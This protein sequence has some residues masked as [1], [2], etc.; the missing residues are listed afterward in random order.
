[1]IAAVLLSLATQSA[2]ASMTPVRAAYDACVQTEAASIGT[3]AEITEEQADLIVARCHH[4]IGPVID[5]IVVQA[6]PLTNLPPGTETS[7]IRRSVAENN[8]EHQ[9]KMAVS[10]HV[11]PLP[12]P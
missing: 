4:L 12:I 7:A 2:V 8:T 1:V 9:A 11:L 3:R 6:G 5:Q 10:A